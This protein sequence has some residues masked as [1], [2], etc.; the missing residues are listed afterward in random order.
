LSGHFF[1][2]MPDME[3]IMMK[4]KVIAGRGLVALALLGFAACGSGDKDTAQ[5][6]DEE[7]LATTDQGTAATGTAETDKPADEPINAQDVTQ[8]E[9]DKQKAEVK[10][11]VEAKPKPKP[12]AETKK[13]EPPPAPKSV[14]VTVPAGSALQVAL[15][16]KLR[17]DSNAVGDPVIATLAAAIMADGETAIP[18]GSKLHGTITALEEPHRTSG[19]A[20]M[21]LQF[22]KVVTPDGQTYALVTAP[23]SFE[24][25]KDKMSDEVKVGAGAVIGGA[26]GAIASK[27]SKKGAAI[28]AA[29]GAAAGGATA[30]ATKGKQIELAPGQELSVEVTQP[31]QVEVPK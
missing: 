22:D 10:P 27:N 5:T 14:M 1:Q 4:M 15:D 19:K 12:P 13:E 8:P 7:Q 17:T 11:K 29:V 3:G 25:E 24:G 23:L 20:Q 28:G 26:I 16:T 9:P 6:Q 2:T 18:A 21:T 30:L 31:A